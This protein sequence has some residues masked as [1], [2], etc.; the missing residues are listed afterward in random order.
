MNFNFYLACI[1]VL[2]EHR[3]KLNVRCIHEAKHSTVK[4]VLMVFTL[5][6]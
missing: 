6:D 1:L 2:K 3:V 4:L 5:V